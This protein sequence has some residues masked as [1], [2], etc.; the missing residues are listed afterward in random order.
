VVADVF[1]FSMEFGVMWEA[2]ILKA[3][4]AGIL[5]S[6]GEMDAFSHMEIRPLNLEQMATIP[7]DI[8][9]YQSVL[10]AADNLDELED[11][12]GGFFDSVDDDLALRLRA[13][14]ATR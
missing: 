14:A 2:G 10:F 12:V 11:V 5:S 4:G 9:T 6:Y 1:W 13:D 8:T 3:Y 7:Y